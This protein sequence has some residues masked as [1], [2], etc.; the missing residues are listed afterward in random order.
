MRWLDSAVVMGLLVLALAADSRALPPAV[1]GDQDGWLDGLETALGSDP[2]S[3]AETPESIAAPPTCFDGLDNDGD[4]TTDVDDPGC[5]VPVAVEGTFPPAGMDVFDSHMTLEGYALATPFGTCSVD[6]DAHGPTVI[7]RGDPVTLGGGLRQLSVE[8]I[9]MQLSGTATVNAGIG[10][11]TLPAGDIPVT[12]IESPSLT[13]TGMV[14]DTNADPATDFPADSFFDVFFEVDVNGT[15]L[16]GGPP[17][18]PAGDPV[19][20]ANVIAS[21]PPYH[22]AKNPNCYEVQ[23]LAHEHCPKAP[24]DHYKCYAAKLPKLPKRT[25]SLRDQFGQDDAVVLRPR[26]LCTPTTKGAEP[27]YDEASHLTCYALKPAKLKHRVRVHTQFGQ[28]VDV[29]TKKRVML[30]LPT[31]KNA[32][33]DA[34]EL[35]HFACYSGKFPRLSPR[36]VAL[37]DQFK[38]EDTEVSKPLLLCNPVSKDGGPIRNPLDHLVFYKLKPEKERRTVQFAN[39]FHGGSADVRKSAMLGVPTGKVD[40][41]STTTTTGPVTTTTLTGR[42]LQP[43]TPFQ[44]VPPGPIC[45]ADVVP[46]PD[47]CVAQPDV[48]QN[49]HV[50]RTISVVVG[51]QTFGPFTDPNP[52]ACGHGIVIQQPGCPPDDVP[53]C[54]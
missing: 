51:A 11:C 26:F 34:I 48:C 46:S 2:T 21:L 14:A 5:S 41:E 35:D 49:A 8:M 15:L 20:V 16:P 10:N 52:P 43:A 31:E 25:V 39:Q 17:G 50:H 9:A 12:V 22:T 30:C 32:E 53:P 3:A 13:T 42:A 54:N 44:G 29:T 18:G 7:Q 40:L 24:P 23:G 45:L 27:L 33:G 4:A 6:F 47:G 28:N 38:T 36:P 1:D 19:R 37:V